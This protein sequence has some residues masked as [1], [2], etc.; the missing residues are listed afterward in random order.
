MNTNKPVV[1]TTDGSAHSHQVLPHAA[2]L[3]LAL[4]APLLLLQVLDENQSDGDRAHEA[5]QA[6][7]TRLGI[8]GEARIEV[9]EGRERTAETLLRVAE[10]L[11]AAVLAIDS[12][13]HGALRHALHGSVALD[14]LKTANLPLLVSGPNLEVA[15]VEA[16]PYRIVAT[17]DGSQPSEALLRELG[18]LAEGSGCEV[19]LLRVH[20]D[21]P[22]G[23]DN[24]AVLQACRD[25]LVTA[26]GLLPTSLKVET[27]V[28]EIPRGAG[29]DTAIIEWAQGLGAHALAMSTH[30]YSA[31]RH[32]VMGSV[33]LTLLGRS[34]L[35]I[36]LSRAEL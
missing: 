33:S 29:V 26:R 14:V 22:G 2:L 34:P 31:R 9:R 28:R 1:V 24:A 30:G 3:A 12:R 19:T 17:T 32:V 16:A 4:K 8:E 18:T 15:A 6:T 25:E 21:E 35:P 5:A 36:L 13:G 11:N 27:V 20:E 23:Q 7:L 10:G